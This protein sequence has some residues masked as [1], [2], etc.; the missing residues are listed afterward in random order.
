MGR[1]NINQSQLLNPLRR[2]S[3]A[4]SLAVGFNP[5]CARILFPVASATI[6]F[7]RRS[8]DVGNILRQSRGLKPT[9]KLKAPLTR[10]EEL[11]SYNHQENG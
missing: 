6:E 1:E 11:S 7:N 10:Q 4:L 5:R 3:G 9:A 8:R 2:V